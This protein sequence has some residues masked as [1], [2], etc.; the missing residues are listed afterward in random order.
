MN[1]E[2]RWKKVEPTDHGILI[3]LEQAD[4]ENG[5]CL[6]DRRCAEGDVFLEMSV[7]EMVAN[8]PNCSD[9]WACSVRLVTEYLSAHDGVNRIWLF[10]SLAK[11]K[12]PDW[13]SDID[14]AVKG[15]E[16][17]ALGCAWSELDARIPPPLDLIRWEDASAS[18]RDEITRIGILLYEA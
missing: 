1:D 9:E 18:L 3:R 7:D 17:S 8:L 11:G 15:L 12:K 13:R 14:I 5:S 16:P 10:G 6:I 2:V 4:L